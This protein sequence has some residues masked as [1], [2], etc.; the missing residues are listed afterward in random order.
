MWRAY[1]SCTHTSVFPCFV[2]VSV[3]VS[4]F[5]FLV[6]FP[7]L[8]H[9]AFFSNLPL[10]HFQ[11]TLSNTQWTQ[12]KRAEIKSELEPQLDAYLASK[13]AGAGKNVTGMH[14]AIIKTRDQKKILRT[15]TPTQTK[16]GIKK[17][18]ANIYTTQTQKF[19]IARSRSASGMLCIRRES[20]VGIRH[21]GEYSVTD[22]EHAF[23]QTKAKYRTKKPSDLIFRHWFF[24]A[25]PP[26]SG[27][28]F[29]FFSQCLWLRSPAPSRPRMHRYENNYS[30]TFQY[31]HSH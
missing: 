12:E 28:P 13:G 26:S 23:F 18:I 7:R 21:R 14:P 22:K 15:A 16:L 11:M 4:V 27:A 24:S 6:F 8:T 31:F 17:H 1:F 2:C 30:A 3:S 10:F 25:P 19:V 29:T 20:V 9:L 5:P